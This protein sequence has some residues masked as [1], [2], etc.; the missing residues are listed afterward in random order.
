LPE[1]K[2][3][4]TVCC[5]LAMPLEIQTDLII[6]RCLAAGK[7]VFVPAWHQ[8]RKK[9]MLARFKAEDDL[10]LGRFNVLEP[11]HPEWIGGEKAGLALV[12]GV[13]FDRCCGRLGHGCGYYDEL[14][15]R[16]ELK[17]AFKI[18]LAFEFQMFDKLPQHAGDVRMDAVITETT[19]YGC[20]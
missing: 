1:W 2:E 15:Y 7:R 13:A 12:P 20:R 10:Q 18:G 3:A 6:E 19:V 17:S 8:G 16:P 14:L 9:Y 5:Y 11:V 4:K